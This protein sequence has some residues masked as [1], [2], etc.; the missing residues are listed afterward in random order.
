MG[1]VGHDAEAHRY[2]ATQSALSDPGEFLGAL[3]A[4]EGSIPAIY[5]AASGLVIHF[6]L[7]DLA[8]AG[9]L[10]DRVREVDT[11]YAAAIFARLFELDDR[12]LAERR[13][14]RH[15]LVGCCRDFTLIFLAIARALGIPARGRVGF[16]SY[17][18]PGVFND[19]EIAEVWDADE[20]RW[21]LVDPQL[22]PDHIDPNDGT[23]I[24]PT[25]VPRDR[26]L[27]AGRAWQRCRAMEL[28]ADRFVV[29]PAIETAFL[30]GWPYLAHNLVFDLAAL[31]KDELL[32]WDVW[33]LAGEVLGN[34]PWLHGSSLLE[35][36]ARVSRTPRLE[37]LRTLYLEQPS[38]CV[39]AEV[40]SFSPTGAPPQ[41]VRHLP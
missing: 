13:E 30:Q 24:D 7:D 41:T 29:H 31:N 21:R 10:A 37:D 22:K 4:V 19:H 6:R 35:R 8:D 9:I 5:A 26:F 15:R 39:P 11:R 18:F 3:R 20:E 2:Y 25:D 14:P 27:V 17:F 16:S 40:T 34:P 38:L 23:E 32:L 28:D 33:G 36:V 1:E 12:P